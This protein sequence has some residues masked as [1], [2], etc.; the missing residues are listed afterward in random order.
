MVLK[1]AQFPPPCNLCSST[2]T[3]TPPRKQQ[4]RILTIPALPALPIRVCVNGCEQRKGICMW[5]GLWNHQLG[6]EA[7]LLQACP[8]N[9]DKQN[10]NRGFDF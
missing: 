10:Q 9:S 2:L 8:P 5:G 4:G 7:L 3:A 1:I 6:Q